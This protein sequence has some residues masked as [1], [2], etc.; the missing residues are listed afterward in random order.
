M[1]PPQL[2]SVSPKTLPNI[3][4]VDEIGVQFYIILYIFIYMFPANI[5]KKSA[6]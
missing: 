5:Q 3:M 6:V 1:L 4:I 2:H